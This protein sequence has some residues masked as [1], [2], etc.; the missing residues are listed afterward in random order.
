MKRLVM[1]VCVAL[2]AMLSFSAIASNRVGVV[3]MQRLIQQSPKVKQLGEQI[4]AKF[5]TRRNKVIAMSKK[6]QANVVKYQKN[7]AV[8]SA[9]QLAAL[10]AKITA[11]ETQLRTAQVKL[12]QDLFHAQNAAMTKF[13]AKLRNIVKAIAS[14]KKL[15]MVLPRNTVLYSDNSLD[16]TADVEKRLQ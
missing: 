2:A 3:N 6:L 1:V 13:V 10:K 9:A 11:Q 4:K 8:M 15:D 5:A 7:K 14:E 12:Q 16:I